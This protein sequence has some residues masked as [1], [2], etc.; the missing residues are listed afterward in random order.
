MLRYISI[1]ESITENYI[2]TESAISIQ[3]FEDIICLTFRDFDWYT[4]IHFK[5]P[6]LIDY[7]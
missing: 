5:R 1:S 7:Y 6:A 4:L 2:M 3:K